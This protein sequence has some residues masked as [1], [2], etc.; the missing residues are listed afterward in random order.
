MNKIQVFKK[1]TPPITVSDLERELETLSVLVDQWTNCTNVRSG[2]K[3][4][5]EITARLHPN[6]MKALV[7]I[8]QK[9]TGSI[10]KSRNKVT[11]TNLGR[12]R[13]HSAA[14]IHFLQWLDVLVAED[15]TPFL[16]RVAVSPDGIDFFAITW[17]GCAS[18]RC[19]NT[20]RWDD[21][22][23]VWE[24]DSADGDSSTKL[25]RDS[26]LP[27]IPLRMEKEAS[28]VVSDWDRHLEFASMNTLL[29]A[30]DRFGE[31][32]LHELEKAEVLKLLQDAKADLNPLWSHLL[33]ADEW[34]VCDE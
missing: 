12:V 31:G 23:K 8:A 7:M 13:I 5:R 14:I 18:I 16:R 32:E 17:S 10:L 15:G 20:D 21:A 26:V 9:Q 27:Y 1:E 19:A 33:H 2:N 24:W 3:L 6:L 30:V 29:Q 34:E 4:F 22:K 25:L 11:L 28:L